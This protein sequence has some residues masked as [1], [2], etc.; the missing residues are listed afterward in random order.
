MKDSLF[1]TRQAYCWF[2]FFFN[3]EKFPIKTDTW[4]FLLAVSLNALFDI[5]QTHPHARTHTHSHAKAHPY[6]HTRTHAHSF[7]LSLSLSL[8]CYQVNLLTFVVGANGGDQWSLFVAVV[9]AA[10][11]VV[12]VAVAVADGVAVVAAVDS[13]NVSHLKPLFKC[14][15]DFFSNWTLSHLLQFPPSL[16]LTFIMLSLSPTHLSLCLISAWNLVSGLFLENSDF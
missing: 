14:F 8:L 6:T 4:Y 2:D 13:E 11:A 1:L 3:F 16:S 15:N 9:A 7:S 5:A 12:V 10:A